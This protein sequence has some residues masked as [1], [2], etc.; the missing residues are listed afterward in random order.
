[1]GTALV[2]NVPAAALSGAVIGIICFV[3]C[4]GMV[5]R[6]MSAIWN[7]VESNEE[8]GSAAGTDDVAPFDPFSLRVYAPLPL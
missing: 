5:N 3:L 4:F 6:T 1:M 8:S 7:H 2:I